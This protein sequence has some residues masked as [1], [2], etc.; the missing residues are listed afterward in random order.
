MQAYTL[1]DPGSI[2]F[3]RKSASS[4][5]I[6]IKIRR[7]I[8]KWRQKSSKMTLDGG[9]G[10]LKVAHHFRFGENRGFWQRKPVAHIGTFSFRCIKYNLVRGM[11]L[12]Q[13]PNSFW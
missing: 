2:L 5:R 11:I 1:D 10:R 4:Q 7:R 13:N 9:S 12:L 8:R 3:L 6:L